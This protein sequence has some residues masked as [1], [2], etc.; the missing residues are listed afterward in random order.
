MVGPFVSEKKDVQNLTNKTTKQPT[1]LDYFNY[2]DN[3]TEAL[4]MHGHARESKICY[5]PAQAMSPTRGPVG[6]GAFAGLFSRC[7]ITPESSTVKFISLASQSSLCWKL[8][9]V[10]AACIFGQ[11]AENK[12]SQFIQENLFVQSIRVCLS[13]YI[14]FVEQ[15]ILNEVF[16]SV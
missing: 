8:G 12:L 9:D 1:W 15:L 10:V 13:C 16:I 2:N 5:Q 14:S 4:V 3:F 6:A 7:P 11:Y